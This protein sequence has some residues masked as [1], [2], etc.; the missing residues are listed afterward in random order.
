MESIFSLAIEEHI[1]LMT[2]YLNSNCDTTEHEDA[3]ERLN[4]HC[5]YMIELGFE[6]A[7]IERIEMDVLTA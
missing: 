4:R 3:S 2:G 6:W 5:G 7:D 1:H